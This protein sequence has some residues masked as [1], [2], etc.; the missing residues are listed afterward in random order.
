MKKIVLLISLTIATFIHTT[1]QSGHD[2]ALIKITV[3]NYV[4]GF[5]T[6]DTARMARAIHPELAKR[7][8]VRDTSGNIMLSN[9][10]SSQLLYNTRRNRNK[11][12][13]YPEQ[14]FKADIIIYDISKN[15]ATAKVVTNKYHFIDYLHLGKFRDEW[16]IVNVLWELTE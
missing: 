3:M 16:K 13:K 6:S 12:V 14:P 8:I 1:G 7:I 5:Y 4:E 2:T 10:G 9:M 11:D 15:T